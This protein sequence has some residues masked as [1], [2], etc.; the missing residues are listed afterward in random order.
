MF[1]HHAWATLRLIEHCA[2]L[3]PD[4]LQSEVPGTRGTIETTLVHLVAADQR[5]LRRMD[6]QT[7]A[8]LV[9]EREAVPSLADL[10]K[11]IEAQAA[12]W[13]ALI[14]R[15]P[16]LDVTIPAQGDFPDAP[17]AENLLFLQAI[18]HGNDHRTHICTILGAQGLEALDL[19]GWKYWSEGGR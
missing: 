4:Q 7:A 6:G 5:Y 12:R 3:T 17:H 1:Q 15:A 11:A 16:E 9:S 18:H 10:R 19:D 8:I 2:G 13:E 14:E